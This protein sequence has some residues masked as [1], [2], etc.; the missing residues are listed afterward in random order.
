MIVRRILLLQPNYGVIGKRTWKLIPYNL[1]I[2]QASLD[3]TYETEIFDPNFENLSEE[4][5]RTKIRDFAPDVVGIT[6]FSTEYIKEISFHAALIKEELPNTVVIL[7]GVYPTVLPEQAIADKNIDYCV[8]GEGEYRLPQLLN[9]IND[10]QGFSDIDGIGYQ[11]EGQII[12]Q[13]VTEF[14]DDLDSIPLPD[15]YPLNI[16]EYGNYVTKFSHTIIPRQFPSAVTISSRGCPYQCVFCAGHTVSGRKVRMRSAANILKEIDGLYNEEGIR[17][18]IFLDDHFLFSEKRAIEIMKGLIDRD[19]ELTWKCVNLA[20]FSLTE[21]ILKLM[22]KSGCYQLTLSIESGDQDVL[23]NLIR[24]PVNLDNAIVTVKLALEMGFE[25][26]SNFVFGFPGETWEQIRRTCKFADDLNLTMAN[27]HI[28]T[29]LP[30]TSLM[31]TCIKEGLVNP[32]EELSGYTHGVINTAEFSSMELQILRAFEWDRINF[33]NRKK[34][35]TIARM[36]GI[37]LNEVEG[38]R[39]RTRRNLGATINWQN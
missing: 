36:E 1:G 15:Y 5:I 18:I 3:S 8:L 23:K 24:K 13:P 27:F 11:K 30:K 34:V 25:V 28:A 7:G 2:L 6:S 32:D 38:W 22:K 10:E 16:Q 12:V 37:T 4:T 33:K 26:I 35:E 39:V 17:E 21:E 19:Y 20:I 29:P 9:A 31:A 14:I